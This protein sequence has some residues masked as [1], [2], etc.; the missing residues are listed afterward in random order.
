MIRFNCIQIILD[1]RPTVI[2]IYEGG[3]RHRVG[4]W[5]L[6]WD[7][8]LWSGFYLGSICLW[9]SSLAIR[10]SS[11]FSEIIFLL[12][13]R[14]RRPI[15]LASNWTRLW[16]RSGWISGS[17]ATAFVFLF[18]GLHFTLIWSWFILI[19]L[20]FATWER[21]TICSD[22]AAILRNGQPPCFSPPLHQRYPN[23]CIAPKK[24]FFIC[25][26]LPYFSSN[27]QSNR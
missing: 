2:P 20:R 24:L 23:F 9:G 17:T 19:L 5:F 6:R 4:C 27:A 16:L 22:F 13:I 18:S 11:S 14:F 21:W 7:F 8:I 12:W 25:P 1:S 15:W 3:W 10:S 26:H